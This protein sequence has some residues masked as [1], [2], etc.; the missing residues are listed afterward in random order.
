VPDFNSDLG[1]FVVEPT[2]MLLPPGQPVEAEPM[3]STLGVTSDA[4]PLTVS[5]QIGDRTEKR[6]L[7]LRTIQAPPPPA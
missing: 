6:I 3:T 7:T 5:V 2:T 4:I 1:N